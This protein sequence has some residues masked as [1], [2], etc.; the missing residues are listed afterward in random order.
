MQA[1]QKGFIGSS[2]TKKSKL[3]SQESNFRVDDIYEAYD[4]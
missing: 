2:A 3:D 1:V 4:V